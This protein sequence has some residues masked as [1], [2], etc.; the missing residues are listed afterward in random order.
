ML[1]IFLCYF[2]FKFGDRHGI[3]TTIVDEKNG[4]ALLFFGLIKNVKNLMTSSVHENIISTNPTCDVFLHTYNFSRFTN[5]RNNENN[6]HYSLDGVEFLN[7]TNYTI[8]PPEEPELN[9]T[10]YLQFFDSNAGWHYPNSM[11]N[12][13]KQWYSIEKVW[14]LMEKAEKVYDRVG[15]FRLD[16]LFINKIYINDGDAVVPHFM[17]WKGVLMND[18][19]FYG[20]YKHAR[21]WALGRFADV[22]KYIEK[23]KTLHSEKYMY[24]RM[25]NIP[26][27]KK[28]ICFHRIRLTGSVL[29]DC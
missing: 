3:K 22:P 8:S 13:L 11:F 12:M 5:P 24:Y 1:N 6:A 4:C 15:F 17:N 9:Y 2:F 27:Q 26:V 10:F 14:R 21:H 18:R 23:Y 25:K 16:V 28:H 29:H 7:T 20:L 19:M